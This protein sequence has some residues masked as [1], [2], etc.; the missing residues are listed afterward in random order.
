MSNLLLLFIC[1]ASGFVLRKSEIVAKEA[2]IQLNRIIIYFF[3]PVLTLKHLPE[4]TFQSKFWWL[5]VCPWLIFLGSFLF[6]IV[7]GQ[8][9]QTDR[10]VTGALILTSG[11]GSTSFVGFPIFEMLYGEEGLAMGI[12][13]SLAGTLVVFNTIG[14]FTGFWFAE[15][16]PSFRKVILKMFRFVPFITFLVALGLN[17]FGYHHPSV[18]RNLLDALSKPFSVL[19]LLTIGIQLDFSIN[20]AIIPQ[21]LIGQFY[22]LILAPIVIYLLFSF[23]SNDLGI[24][25]KVCILGAAIGSMNAIS[26]VA[27][28]LGLSPKLAIQMPSLGIPLSVPLLLAIDYFFF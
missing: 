20:K 6:F 17:Y 2:S 10:K 28:E 25:E 9:F 22:K 12:I 16:R 7:L 11:I 18:L 23:L 8:L 3:I 24:L 19:V 14:M 26:I 13:M 27:A 1:I 5:I 15:G 21:L 4:L